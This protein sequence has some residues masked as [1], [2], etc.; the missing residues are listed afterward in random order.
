MSSG[1]AGP[2]GRA[3]AA[4]PR[5]RRLAAEP[6]RSCSRAAPG[7]AVRGS[8]A[9]EERLAPR[10]STAEPRAIRHIL[11]ERFGLS[12]PRHVLRRLYEATLGNP[13]FALELGRT[14][15]EDGLPAAG[16]DFPVPAAVED[17]LGTRVAG[18]SPS[19]RR[20]LLAVAL[21]P[22]VRV[23]QLVSLADSDAF[24]AAVETGVLVVEQRCSRVPSPAGC[25]RGASVAGGRAS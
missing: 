14:L 9:L 5:S 24:D 4:P 2:R 25:G 11:L 7:R 1:S 8:S 16:E 23:G 13:L 15:R 22:T 12:L 10:A 3:L 18:L 21:G 6:W 20:V 17:L 19:V